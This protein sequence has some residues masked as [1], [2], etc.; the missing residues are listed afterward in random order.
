[1]NPITKSKRLQ[2]KEEQ[3]FWDRALFAALGNPN[4][5]DIVGAVTD[6]DDAIILRRVREYKQVNGRELPK[7]NLSQTVARFPTHSPDCRGCN[8]CK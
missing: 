7:P 4:N 3:E 6:A 1:M 8:L 2:S 5:R